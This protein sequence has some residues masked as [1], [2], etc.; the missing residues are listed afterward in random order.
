MVIGDTGDCG[1]E[2]VI[3]DDSVRIWAGR[4]RVDKL[5][6]EDEFRWKAPLSDC[7]LKAS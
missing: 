3:V 1:P 2:L 4:D 6:K 5:V 7:L